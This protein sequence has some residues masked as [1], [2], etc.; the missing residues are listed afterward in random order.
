[1]MTRRVQRGRDAANRL[2]C[3]NNMK[4]FSIALH[5]FGNTN[6][7]LPPYAGLI[8]SA[9]G[10]AHFFLLPFIEQDNLSKQAN[11]QSF[12]VATAVVKTYVCVSE[13]SVQ[14]GQFPSG[15]PRGARLAR[16]GT[17]FGSTNYPVNA[18]VCD[19]NRTITGITDGTS[20]TVGFAERMADCT[21]PNYP[22]AGSTPNLGTGSFTYSIWARGMKAVSSTHL[23]LPTILRVQDT[24]LIRPADNIGTLLSI[25]LLMH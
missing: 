12:N 22:R 13:V 1:M 17:G 11:G 4:L 19:G 14:A 9:N 8:G 16:N 21:G 5:S 3:A 18:A 15:H 24:V 10:S 20:N 7:K 6:G 23:T 2:S 25:A